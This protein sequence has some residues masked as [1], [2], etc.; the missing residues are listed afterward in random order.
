MKGVRPLNQE[1]VKRVIQTF[2]DNKYAQRDKNLFILGLKTGMRISELLSLTV[3]DVWQYDQPVDMLSLRKQVVKG[4]KEARA[5][6]LNKD[7]KNAIREL[8]EW[9]STQ[10][11]DLT[12]DTPLFASQKG[13]HITRM[14]AHRI[15]NRAFKKA[16]LTG[17]L[18]THSMR[19]TFGTRVYSATKDI[20]TTK[21]LLGHANVNTTQKYIGVGMD[22]LKAAVDAI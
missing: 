13:G 16:G 5:I 17:K 3:G 14:Q 21:E 10:V 2:D 6:P 9:L 18:A 20:M 12:Q 15:L 19:K 22:A 1:E 8:K 4:K 7:A 11:V